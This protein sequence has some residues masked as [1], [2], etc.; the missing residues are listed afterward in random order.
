MVARRFELEPLDTLFFRGNRP[1]QAEDAGLAIARSTMP[2]M[3]SATSGALRAAIGTAA[4][5]P[6]V[7]NWRRL[8]ETN[9]VLASLGD[10]PLD[11]GIWRFGPPMVG[12][13]S[14]DQ[15]QPI[16]ILFPCPSHVMG[17][18]PRR[19]EGPPFL[20]LRLAMPMLVDDANGVRTDQRLA[21]HQS[22]VSLDSALDFESAD[23]CF[24]TSRGMKEVSR[25]RPPPPDTVV[26]SESLWATQA[27]VGVALDPDRKTAVDGMLY[28]AEHRRPLAH[29]ESRVV[30]SVA[31]WTAGAPP[32]SESVDQASFWK[33]LPTALPFGGGGRS[34][35]L[36]TTRFDQR[37]LWTTADGKG[38][39]LDGRDE[40]ARSSF[41]DDPRTHHLLFALVL[42]S[43]AQL[44]RADLGADNPL[45]LEGVQLVSMI[46]GRARLQSPW[47][48]SERRRA[49]SS[50][51][52][53]AGSVLFFR[54]LPKGNNDGEVRRNL[55][56][57]L[58]RM[59]FAGRPE[60]RD[61]APTDFLAIGRHT[62]LGYGACLVATWKPWVEG[63]RERS[64]K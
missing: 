33:S 29:A 32:K 16:E 60:E 44:T 9:P 1:F 19:P 42:V 38:E 10:G 35:A 56:S 28:A 25:G 30:F 8:A 22:H 39:H 7:G 13:R 37:R 58:R 20:E 2:P 62:R 55:V 43:P 63:R 27:R 6:G 57:A 47:D 40:I 53:P 52:L 17:R 41:P 5:W 54:A 4:G 23:D 34:I 21:G 12:R 3:P 26:R 11:P 59:T 61:V 15:K 45:G 18:G 24:L 48:S 49:A 36:S 46:H 14:A 51:L 31:A 64:K 50:A